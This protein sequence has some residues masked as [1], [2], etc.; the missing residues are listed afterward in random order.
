MQLTLQI[1]NDVSVFFKACLERG[2]HNIEIYL[3]KSSENILYLVL[4]TTLISSDKNR[5]RITFDDICSFI[6]NEE[7][8]ALLHCYL[9]EPNLELL[10]KEVAEKWNIF[11]QII[12]TGK[13]NP[14][15]VSKWD[16]DK[17]IFNIENCLPRIYSVV[18]IKKTHFDVVNYF[19]KKYSIQRVQIRAEY[20]RDVMKE[21]CDENQLDL[22]VWKPQKL[23]MVELCQDLDIDNVSTELAI[24]YLKEYKDQKL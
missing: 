6:S 8:P 11:E 12:F 13:T 20:F 14:I 17:I 23:K 9:L 18:E 1:N 21:W 19:C 5:T 16:R 24:D 15:F 22:S 4:E 7:C 10:V 2:I 3:K